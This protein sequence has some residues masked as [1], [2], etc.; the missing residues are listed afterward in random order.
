M[1]NNYKKVALKILRRIPVATAA[2]MTAHCL[3]LLMGMKLY[4][5]EIATV[6]LSAVLIFCLSKASHYCI[7]HRL[8]IYYTAVVLV[9]IWYERHVGFDTDLLLWLR[10]LMLTLGISYLIVM[11]FKKCN[12][13]I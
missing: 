4:I 12:N 1:G 6:M 11:C 13:E 8:G 3:T 2:L 5:A 10:V 7:W 9:F